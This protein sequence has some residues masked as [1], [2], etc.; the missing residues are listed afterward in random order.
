MTD[1]AL[2]EV[3][4]RPEVIDLIRRA[5]A[6]DV[7]PGDE[8]TRAL[9]PAGAAA[10]AEIVAR[11]ACTVSGVAV[12]CEV[13]R[14]VDA[15]IACT[16]LA[17]DGTAV[18]A[19]TAVMRVE[20]PARGLLTAERTALNFMQRMSGIA[21]LTRRYA[22]RAAP[23]GTA[24][25]DTRKTAPGLRVL[26]R[27][28][29]LCGGGTN[30]RFGLYDRVLIKDNHRAAW[31]GRTHLGLAEAVAAA[32][33]ACPDLDVEVEVDTLSELEDALSAAP[34]WVLLDNMGCDALRR[35]VERA[36]G[37]VRLE[38]SGGVTLETVGD[39]AATG[40]DAVSVGALTHSAPAADLALDFTA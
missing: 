20:G 2:P 30:H 8:T 13:F 38:A 14:Q 33:E 12:A 18:P 39:I 3:A 21:T 15:R 27:Y 7:G 11:G 34:D 22:E 10:R 17:R 6:E 9:V 16:G 24:V 1:P 25:L 31:T 37:R 4:G 5:L 40:V 19:G 26:D 35:A 23:H 29:V 36:A 28:A 32:R